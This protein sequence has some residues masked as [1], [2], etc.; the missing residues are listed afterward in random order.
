MIP[1]MVPNTVD[2]ADTEIQQRQIDKTV[3]KKLSEPRENETQIPQAGLQ[4]V[5]L[6]PRTNIGQHFPGT[7][8]EGDG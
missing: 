8:W 1:K 4:P 7:L 6:S 5:K 2:I 3:N